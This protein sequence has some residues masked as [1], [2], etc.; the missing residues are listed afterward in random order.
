MAVWSLTYTLNGADVSS[1]VYGRSTIRRARNAQA[2]ATFTLRPASGALDLDALVGQSITIDAN[3]DAL[4]ASRRFTGVVETVA[5]DPASGL[6][7][8]TCVDGLKGEMRA[9]TTAEVLALMPGA[10]WREECFGPESDGW[11]QFR[12][13]VQTLDYSYF[14]GRDGTDQWVSRAAKSTPDLELSH[15]SGQVLEDSVRVTPYR[16]ND[17]VNRVNLTVEA[18]GVI[19]HHWEL[20]C[21]W[22]GYPSSAGFCPGSNPSWFSTPW[23]LPNP[24]QIRSAAQD[25]G[26]KIKQGDGLWVSSG[27][28]GGFHFTGLP[29]SGP[30]T[31]VCGTATLD[32]VWVN[33]QG[34]P[35]DPDWPKGDDSRIT[36][37][38]WIAVYDWEQTARMR[39]DII[40]EAPDGVAAHGERLQQERA[41][42]DEG[43]EDR[44]WATGPS[45]ATPTGGNWALAE[46]SHYQSVELDQAEIDAVIECAVAIEAVKI[47]AAYRGNDVEIEPLSAADAFDLEIADTVRT[48]GVEVFRV[49]TTGVGTINEIN[50]YWDHESGDAGIRLALGTSRCMG[51]GGTDDAVAAPTAPSLYPPYTLD[52]NYSISTHIG[53]L[54][55]S[56]VLNTDWRG[57]I[58]NLQTPEGGG[59]PEIYDQIQFA[60]EYPKRPLA[61][62]ETFEVVGSATYR[63][64]PPHEELT[65]VVA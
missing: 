33:W 53:G 40:V 44:G 21:G 24:D 65:Q 46:G 37:A 36:G 14:K 41:S 51:A 34:D 15:S 25:A 64:Y 62:K 12:E 50:E 54:L 8:V 30:S 6:L 29:E 16:R 49:V 32:W 63:V 18:R 52:Q 48:V 35:S 7:T 20:Q 5:L 23:W 55:S 10:R 56:P 59:T 11:E 26:W 42:Y 22:N 43:E 38:S 3:W 19:L 13:A 39:Y 45:T 60:V 27:S 17:L 1:R 57:W 31:V 47:R 58:T 61:A 28:G 2:I 4:P 9:R